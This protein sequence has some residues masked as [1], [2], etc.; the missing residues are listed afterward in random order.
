MGFLTVAVAW[1]IAAVV[2]ALVWAAVGSYSLVRRI[3]TA[4]DRELD[5]W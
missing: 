4:A 3:G 2:I 5:D 1:F